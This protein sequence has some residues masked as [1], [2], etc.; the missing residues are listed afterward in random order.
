MVCVRALQSRRPTVPRKVPSVPAPAHGFRCP[1]DVF[2]L[3][4]LL[5]PLPM[6]SNGPMDRLVTGFVPPTGIPGAMSRV[7]EVKSLPLV[8]WQWALVKH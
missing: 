7:G 3:Q 4:A 8:D 1:G 6:Q 2:E 5:P